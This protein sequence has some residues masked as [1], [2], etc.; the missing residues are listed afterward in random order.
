MSR[1]QSRR[2]GGALL[3]GSGDGL[4]AEFKTDLTRQIAPVLAARADEATVLHFIQSLPLCFGKAV[5]GKFKR[6]G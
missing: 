6:S 2:I 5:A 1:F 3:L 4:I